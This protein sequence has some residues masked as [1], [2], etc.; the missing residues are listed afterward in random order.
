M[1]AYEV[2]GLPGLRSKGGRGRE[3]EEGRCGRRP[4][5]RERW[6]RQGA[7][8]GKGSAADGHDVVVDGE[9]RN[10]KHVDEWVSKVT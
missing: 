10:I 2:P 8:W 1:I 7:R 3:R 4:A 6:A 9:G 5:E